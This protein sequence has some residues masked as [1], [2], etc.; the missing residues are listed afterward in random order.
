MVFE[1]LAPALSDETIEDALGAARGIGLGVARARAFSHLLPRVPEPLEEGIVKAGMAAAS[2]IDDWYHQFGFIEA[3]GK[4]L[5]PDRSLAAARALDRVSSPAVHSFGL[6]VAA[7][8]MNLDARKDAVARVLTMARDVDSGHRL[9]KILDAASPHLEDQQLER[10]LDLALTIDEATSSA[11]EV[12][13]AAAMV[14]KL[15][16]VPTRA[17]LVAGLAGRIGPS[18][19]PWVL[20]A[21]GR[22]DADRFRCDALVA[23]APLTTATLPDATLACA[24]G[25][26][27]DDYRAL[28]LGEIAAYLEPKAV[29]PVLDAVVDLAL[30]LHPLPAAVALAP[31]VARVPN[32]LGEGIA[33]LLL[34]AGSHSIEYISRRRRA[35][36]LF[37][38]RA[39]TVLRK[40]ALERAVDL[41][42]SQA[43][44]GNPL[45]DLVTVRDF[46]SELTK[47]LDG[48]DRVVA[49]TALAGATRVSPRGDE[50]K[51]EELAETLTSSDA[52][53]ALA[54]IRELLKA[55]QARDELFRT[56]RSATPA[57]A[58]LGGSEA[59]YGIWRAACFTKS[60]WP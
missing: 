19:Y 14:L 28:A 29:A 33:E 9:A 1:L 48:D 4:E 32:E 51:L 49:E 25:L 15:D 20:E 43:S 12:G 7:G 16:N 22:I 26:T 45:P 35:N 31:T 50:Q 55:E 46:L 34:A 40:K 56:L 58:A 23:I 24:M 5:A 8:K 13:P 18:C 39:S 10:A 47:H 52:N 41:V 37:A 54:R 60:W 6:A 57:L 21:I 2:E 3:L 38:E 30:R 44:S 42:Q 17:S 59:I 11:S 36:A 53:A 27:N